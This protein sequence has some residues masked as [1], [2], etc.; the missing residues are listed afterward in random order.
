[1]SQDR[2]LRP[3]IRFAEEPDP[4]LSEEERRLERALKR[5]AWWARYFRERSP[6]RFRRDA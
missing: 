1:M 6:S 2:S 4:A 3:P 5:E